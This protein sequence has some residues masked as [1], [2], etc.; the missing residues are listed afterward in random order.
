MQKAWHARRNAGRAAISEDMMRSFILFC[1]NHKICWVC[2]KVCVCGYTRILRSTDMH[3]T[4]LY[5][6]SA[7]TQT[8]SSYNVYVWLLKSKVG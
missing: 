7:N 5:T 2:V 6:Q 3:N 8:H 4:T 1:I